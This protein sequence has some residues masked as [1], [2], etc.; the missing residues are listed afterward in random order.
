MSVSLYL[1]PSA[2]SDRFCAIKVETSDGHS[3]QM[4]SIY[5]PYEG[6]A[7]SFP[8]HIMKEMVV[9]CVGHG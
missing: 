4:F 8:V 7:S 9:G 2:S 6:Q 3:F 5:M 1:S